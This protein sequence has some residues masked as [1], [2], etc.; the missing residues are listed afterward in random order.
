M[1]ILSTYRRI[2]IDD[3]S[4]RNKNTPEFDWLLDWL[5]ACQPVSGYFI[6]RGEGIASIY[7]YI[8]IFV[9]SKNVLVKLRGF[10]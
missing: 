6:L 4:G 7:I 10:K 8:Y 1:D 3:A 5:T 2:I 9:K